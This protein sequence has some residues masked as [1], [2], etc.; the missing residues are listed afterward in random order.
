M[1][2]ELVVDEII[3][4]LFE[5]VVTDPIVDE[6]TDEVIWLALLLSEVL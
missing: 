3:D 4:R 2:E 1:L 6:D 5:S